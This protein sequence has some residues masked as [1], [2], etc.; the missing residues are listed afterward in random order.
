MARVFS[1]T[2]RTSC[3]SRISRPARALHAIRTPRPAHLS[4]ARPGPRALAA[5]VAALAR[6]SAC[7]QML[8][9]GAAL[10]LAAW[11]ALGA[12]SSVPATARE[13]S[14]GTLPAGTIGVGAQTSAPR[15][16]EGGYVS[17]KLGVTDAGTLA[18][19]G[20]ER[21]ALAGAWYTTMASAYSV[22]CNDGG[23]ATASGIPLD[24]ETPTVAS[25]WLP[26]G[27]LVEVW[28]GDACVTA[29]VTD[30]GPYVSGRE[31]DLAPATYRALGAD[32]TDAWGVRCV[33]YR[34]VG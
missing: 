21:P 32:T 16:G 7:L 31:L 27:T 25:P 22:A 29:T 4:G 1:G 9:C 33:S 14:H 20:S 34:V 3:I 10:A 5:V 8:G 28:Y 13:A 23:T 19:E 17:A 24:D 12:P 6:G 18:S 11:L 15:Q 2:T 30:R 26:L